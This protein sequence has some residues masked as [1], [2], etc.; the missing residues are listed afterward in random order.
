MVYK[1]VVLNPSDTSSIDTIVIDLTGQYFIPVFAVLRRFDIE[2]REKAKGSFTQM[3]MFDIQKRIA[4]AGGRGILVDDGNTI[5]RG[6]PTFATYNSK[7]NEM[8]CYYFQYDDENRDVVFHTFRDE[9]I[10]ISFKPIEFHFNDENKL[11]YGVEDNLDLRYM[12][13][14]CISLCQKK[15]L[16]VSYER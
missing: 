1:D 15:V 5:F 14:R 13:A 9:Y 16:N 8:T 6:L 12:I 10:E 3:A 2:W 7:K 4:S 11:R